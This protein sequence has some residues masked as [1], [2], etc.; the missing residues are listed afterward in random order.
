[1][2]NLLSYYSPMRKTYVL[3][4]FFLVFVFA[5]FGQSPAPQPP[6]PPQATPLAAKATPPKPAPFSPQNPPKALTPPQAKELQEALESRNLDDIDLGQAQQTVL[7]RNPLAKR[8]YDTLQRII[9]SDDDVKSARTKE[10]ADQKIIDAKMAAF[11]KE[12]NLGPEWDYN[13]T[14]GQWIQTTPPKPQGK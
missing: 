7:Q 3:S 1:M 10:D 4:T 8:A 12:Q 2:G 9:N 11:R 5:V 6:K 14:A 13:V